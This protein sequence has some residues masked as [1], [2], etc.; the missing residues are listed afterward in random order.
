[1]IKGIQ[2]KPYIDLS[3]YLDLESFDKLHP[4]IC[5]GFVLAK[6]KNL[7]YRGNLLLDKADQEQVNLEIYNDTIKP[8]WYRYEEYLEL[9]EDHPIKVGAKNLNQNELALY[10]KYA[11][12]AYD[13]YQVFPLFVHRGGCIRELS[14][15]SELFLN[16]IKWIDEINIFTRVSKAYFLLLEP[17]GI[18]IEHK[19]P[20]D[21][22]NVLREFVHIRSDIDRPFYIKKSKDSEKVYVDARV[23][24]FNDQNWHGGEGVRKS[25]Y[26]LR[27]DGSF[28]E[29]IKKNLTCISE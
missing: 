24:Y 21:D 26:A 19:D 1:M 3:N 14:T 2:D 15:I 29:E 5:R 13:P 9:P 27:I 8:V 20:S 6:T 10:L 4:E 28:T 16:V 12:G 11:M 18:S 22:P 25:S 17:D 23:S 7:S